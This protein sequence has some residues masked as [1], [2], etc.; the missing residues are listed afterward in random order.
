MKVIATAKIIAVRIRFLDRPPTLLLMLTVFSS[1]G[2]DI[3]R[4]SVESGGMPVISQMTTA[5]CRPGYG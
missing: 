3:T 2:H 5:R 1:S 4:S